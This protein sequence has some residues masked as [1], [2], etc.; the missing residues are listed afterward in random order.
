MTS[1]FAEAQAAFRL[2]YTGG[3]PWNI[4]SLYHSTQTNAPENCLFLYAC[5]GASWMA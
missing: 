1:K 4:T 5:P 3:S 2:T